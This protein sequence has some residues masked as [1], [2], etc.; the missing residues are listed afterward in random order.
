MAYKISGLQKSAHN[1]MIA[2]ERAS[3]VVFALKSYARYDQSG[4]MVQAGIIEGIETVLTLYHNQIKHS[5][6]VFRHYTEIPAIWCY[7]DELNQVWTNLIHNALQAMDYHGKLEIE[8]CDE[9]P[10]IRVSITDSGS[11]IPESIRDK[12]FLPFFTTKS[13]GEGSGLGLDIVKRIIDKHNGQIRFET[14]PGRTAFHVFLPRL[15]DQPH[16]ST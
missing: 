9:N 16:S 4:S 5:I 11:G 1:I 8:V 2:T 15:T 6:E 7:P 14:Q 10:L 3:K 13:Q 12:I